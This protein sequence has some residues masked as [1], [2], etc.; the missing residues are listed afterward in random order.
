MAR[1]FNSKEFS[2]FHYPVTND[3]PNREC[4]YRNPLLQEQK[5]EIEREDSSVK[6]FNIGMNCGAVAGQS[7]M[8][9]HV[10]IIPRREGDVTQYAH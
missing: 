5:S 9:C 2:N 10:H 6:G 1:S 7:V 8:H 3:D 4:R